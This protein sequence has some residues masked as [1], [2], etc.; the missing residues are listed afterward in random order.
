SLARSVA[1]G[2]RRE[3][4]PYT[5]VATERTVLR[6]LGVDGVDSEEVPVPN[7]VVAALASAGR[8]S[9]GA[10]VWIGSAL[11]GGARNVEEAAARLSDPGSAASVREHPLWRE[12]IAPHVE[13][14]LDRI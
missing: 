5:T 7:K 9:R 13:A 12:A 6:L 11:A 2:V 1:E 8:L 4:E 3:T 10:A 14:G